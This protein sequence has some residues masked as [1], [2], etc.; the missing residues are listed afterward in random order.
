[1][2]KKVK[3]TGALR[4]ELPFDAEP[5]RLTSDAAGLPRALQRSAAS[6]DMDVT[7]LDAAD[8]R[9][10]REGVVLA[11]RVVGGVGEWYLW[12]PSWAPPLPAE[13]V[14][15]MGRNG[16]IPERFAL[17]VTPFLRH[18]TVGPLAMLACRRDEW[19][20]RGADGGVAAIVRDER[21]RIRKADDVHSRYREVTIEPTDVLTGQQREYLISAARAVGATVVPDFPTLR[22]RL[23]TPATGLSSLPKPRLLE[24]DASLEEFVT[25]IFAEHLTAIVRADLDR[26][27]K[28]SADLGLLNDRLW[29]FGRALRGL[30]PVLEPAW[31]EQ[32]EATLEG[33]PFESPTDIEHPTIAVIDAL[34]AG[35][36]APR[37]G[38]L[39]QSHAAQLLFERAQQATYILAERCRVLTDDAPEEA[40]QA[41]LRAAQQLEVAATVLAPL[42]PK[43]IGKLIHRL[44]D[45]LHELGQC[46]ANAFSGEPELD[47]LSPAQAYR[48]G[49]D[50]ERG[51]GAVQARRRQFVEEWPARFRE[52]R[53]LLAKAHKR[54][55]KRYSK[56][57]S[58]T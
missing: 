46:T 15:P 24:R 5:P 10:L 36:R 19:A 35:A 12:A 33:L 25:T 32:L 6:Y 56:Q 21:V 2:A 3:P 58:T 4:F 47:G 22:Q 29:A 16:D 51:R 55:Q 8:G 39:S 37:L 31:R 54:Q 17:L 44:D 20:L 34:V 53:D 57:R 52:A 26:R 23:G 41:A 30:A 7:V 45:L 9:L 11:H 1:M 27:A 18:E 38:D 14:L 13:Q 49:L 42:L 40:W 28:A 50:S 43:S 48:L